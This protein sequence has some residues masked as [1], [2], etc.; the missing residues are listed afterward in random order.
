[1]ERIIRPPVFKGYDISAVF[2]KRIRNIDELDIKPVFLPVQK[3]TDDIIVIKEREMIDK[4]VVADAVI[5]DL[6][7]IAI[8][9]KTADCVP[10]LLYDKKR[11]VIAAVHSGWRGTSKNIVG[12]TVDRMKTDFKSKAI[13]ILAAIGPAICGRCY[14]VGKDVIDEIK[15]LTSFEP[16]AINDKFFVNLKDINR[17]LLI[18]AGLSENHIYVTPDC[19]YC[20]NDEYQ[21]Y[22]YHKNTN[23]F[24]IS[25]IK[26]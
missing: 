2:S 4:K 9:V 16:E 8:G 25:Y 15:N 22:R 10:V 20:Q 7:D 18:R 5:T 24:Q 13:D 19:T 1:M 12:K 21:S 26:L 23:S 3:H 6:K 11:N 14:I 17:K